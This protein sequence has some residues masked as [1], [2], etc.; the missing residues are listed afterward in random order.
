MSENVEWNEAQHFT[1]STGGP[2]VGPQAVLNGVVAR[3]GQD[4]DG[5]TVDV[6]RVAQC[7]PFRPRRHMPR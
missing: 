3:I 2:F 4:F 7:D 5:F 1:Y 6:G